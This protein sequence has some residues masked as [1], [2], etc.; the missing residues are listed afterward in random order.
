[1]DMQSSKCDSPNCCDADHQAVCAA[2][3]ESIRNGDDDADDRANPKGQRD[4]QERRNERIHQ[5]KRF[6]VLNHFRNRNRNGVCHQPD[7]VVHCDDRKQRAGQFALRAIL[8]HHEQ[9]CRGCGCG[10]D[11]AEAKRHWH[12][13]SQ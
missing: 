3:E 11:C 8:A 12:G 10:G 6:A 2:M 7:C 5:V 1:M 4:F 13:E 9:R